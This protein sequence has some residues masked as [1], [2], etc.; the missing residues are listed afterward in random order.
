MKEVACFVTEQVCE[1]ALGAA[2][3]TAVDKTILPKCDSKFEKGIVVAGTMVITYTIARNF[4]KRFLNH[5]NILLDT[6][7]DTDEV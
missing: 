2:I 7:F 5:C 6:N 1:L 4:G 3:G